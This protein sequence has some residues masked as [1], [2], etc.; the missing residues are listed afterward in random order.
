[1]F[2]TAESRPAWALPED[3]AVIVLKDGAEISGEIVEET[4][5][6]VV[7]RSLFGKSTI[8]RTRIKEIRRGTN[9]LREEFNERFEKA[10][11]KKRVP[12][13]FD[14]ARWALDKGLLVEN[15]RALTKVIE[16]DVDH[17]GARKALGHARFDGDWVDDTRVDEMLR[18][19]YKLVG[20]DLVKKKTGESGS[21]AKPASGSS[22]GEKTSVEKR[23]R[24]K[25]VRPELS[26]KEKANLEKERAKR[27]KEAEEFRRQKQREYAGVPWEK[28][29]RI[30][31]P[32][33][34]IECNSTLKVAKTYQWIME[35]LYFELS[36]R[37][38]QKHSRHGGRLPVFI[39]KT[40]EEFNERTGSN[41]GGFYRPANEQVHCYHGTFGL[42]ATTFNVLAHEGTHQFQGRILGNMWNIPIWL[43]EG[44][45]V[46][47]G[48]GSKIDYKKKKIVSGLIPRDRLFHIQDKMKKG[49]HEPLRTLI[50][51]PQARFGGSQYADGWSLVYF[52]FNDKKRGR[53]MISEFWLI[54]VD[55]RTTRQDFVGLAEKYFGDMETLEKEW[56]EYTLSLEPDPP[57][58]V[59]GEKFVSPDFKFEVTRPAPDWEWIVDSESSFTLVKMGLPDYDAEIEIRFM[60][61]PDD[62]SASQ[63][64]S[65][66]MKNTE[67]NYTDVKRESTKINGAAGYMITFKDKPPADED[68]EEDE[69][70]DEE[71][72]DKKE[73]KADK[74]DEEEEEPPVLKEYRVYLLVGV[75]KAYLI[76]CSAPIETFEDFT[77]DFQMTAD[78]FE[79][80][81]S[82]RW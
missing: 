15:K 28:R 43:I 82:N 12:D 31:T 70:E 74:K 73:K 1:M 7:I 46:Y 50:T 53:P 52:L 39:Y 21:S 62:S 45:A 72:A 32:R 77:E 23:K 14:L 57:G 24:P 34:D 56:I 60:N 17:E 6:Y 4:D 2:L 79:L 76:R 22:A 48:D 55:R 68:D 47:F 65:N 80:V 3:K 11:R 26:P 19:G 44:L 8:Q 25:R 75:S 64:V 33:Y 63:F 69:E 27:A 61:K 78:R 18:R 36:R 38:T 41:A 58:E 20:L 54:G 30:K 13:L 67:A 29:H 35:N 51:L 37:F 81:L 16:I 49:T 71:K 5:D 42:T 10:A 59:E 40:K 9:P 66:L